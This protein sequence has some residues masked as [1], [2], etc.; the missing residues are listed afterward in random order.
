MRQ[1]VTATLI[2]TFISAL[3]RN[4]KTAGRVY[5]V[6]GASA[7]LLGW[8]LSTI[9]VDLKLLPETDEL[10]RSLP[11]LK[12]SL[13]INVELASPDLFIPALPGWQERSVFIRQEGALGFFHYDFYAQA[14][15]KV[16]RG[17]DIDLL[18]VN[19]M[20]VRGLVERSKLLEMFSAIEDQLYRYPAINGQSF[21]SA[22]ERA[23]AQS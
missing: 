3:A 19:E 20:L 2:E 7:V 1:P 13:K 22:V 14:L 4:A 15:A 10:L 17:H 8:R 5:I 21:R 16:E 6:G 23:V 9:D 18:D 11:N 12:E